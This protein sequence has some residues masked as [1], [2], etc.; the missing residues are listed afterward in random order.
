MEVEWSKNGQGEINANRTNNPATLAAIDMVTGATFLDPIPEDASVAAHH[1]TPRSVANFSTASAVASSDSGMA[2]PRDINS[3]ANARGNGRVKRRQG[4]CDNVSDTHA[5][6]GGADL[7]AG[8]VA[9]ELRPPRTSLSSEKGLSL[10]SPTA[11]TKRSLLYYGLLAIM[12]AGI[13]VGI[14]FIVVNVANNDRGASTE[15]P[16]ETSSDESTQ[17][18]EADAPTPDSQFPPYAF[19]SEGSEM[20]SSSPSYNLVDVFELDQALL[21]VEGTNSSNLYNSGTP[22]GEC[23]YWMTHVDQVEL[24]VNMVGIERAQQR[25][26][27]CVLYYSTNG[28]FWTVVDFLNPVVHECDWTGVSCNANEV[29]AVILSGINLTGTLPQELESLTNLTL[30]DL[31]NNSISGT[32]PGNL[33]ESLGQ[34]IWIN[35]SWNQLDG[36][37]PQNIGTSPVL[38]NMYLKENRL[39][40]SVPFFPNIQRVLLEKNSLT[41]IDAQYATSAPFLVDFRA[42]ENQFSGPLPTVWNAPSLE[43]LELGVN[44]WTGTIPQDLW[45]LPSLQSLTLSNCQLRG[46]LPA[47]SGGSSFQHVWLHAN[48]LSGSI[49]SEFGSNWSNL[50]SLLLQN[51]NLTG[52]I[53][54]EQ[55][56]RWAAAAATTDMADTEESSSWTCETDCNL[57]TLECSCCTECFPSAKL[58]GR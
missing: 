16:L 49:P 30:L 34:L 4:D 9:T 3:N 54:E 56:A 12:L 52:A 39:E 17:I 7:G 23:R 28:D 15:P 36:T 26:I 14:Y 20:P 25:Y 22:Q 24:R 58:R 51:N 44:A 33:F 45:D 50:T 38:E 37:I 8:G 53:T 21:Q 40:G 18:P 42:Y 13:A 48:Q 31:H 19:D 43:R 47:S 57:P 55:C 46:Q 10:F 11:C 2:T 32:I 41:S 1:A 6:L 29:G 27:L 35:L 5:S